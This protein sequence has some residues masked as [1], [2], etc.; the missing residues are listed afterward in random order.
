M[1]EGQLTLLGG[2]SDSL[3]ED[4]IQRDIVLDLIVQLH[5]DCIRILWHVWEIFVKPSISALEWKKDLGQRQ[6]WVNLHENHGG[7]WPLPC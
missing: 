3:L 5:P 2:S 6:S 1:V 7:C 4:I